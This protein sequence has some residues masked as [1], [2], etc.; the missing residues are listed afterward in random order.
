MGY[1]NEDW[2]RALFTVYTF[3]NIRNPGKSCRK[4]KPKLP[5]LCWASD[6]DREGN[7]LVP[8]ERLEQETEF[9]RLRRYFGILTNFAPGEG[10]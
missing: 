9:G 6:K 1:G 10:G 2:N 8:E 7:L 3:F 4:P 5:L